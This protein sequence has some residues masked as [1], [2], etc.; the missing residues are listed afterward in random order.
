MKEED[1][2]LNNISVVITGKLSIFKNRAALQSAIE[3]AGGK[4]VGS[5]SKNTNYLINNDS[6][7]TSSK[8]ISA[9]KLGIPIVTEAEFV[10]KFLKN[11]LT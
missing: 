7:S 8:N 2:S 11:F 1:A 10:E 3:A 6:T 4:V 5:V 9:Q